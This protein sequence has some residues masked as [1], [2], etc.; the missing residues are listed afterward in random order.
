MPLIGY[1]R[2]STD[3][4]NLGPQL[5][6]LGAAGCTEV[7]EEFAS[8]ANRSRPQLAA[9]IARVRRG[10]TLLVAR[11]DR[12]A[13]SLSHLLDVVETLRA[14]GAYFRSLADP[15]DTSGPSGVLV[16]QMLGAVAEFERSL[17]RERTM[18]GIQ[19]AKA[20]G[21][22]G[23]NPG[24]RARDPDVSRK[25]AA[26]RHA[27]RLAK[28]LPDLE[29]WLPVV[30]RLRPAKPWPDVADA[31]NAAL[32]AGHDRFSTDRLVSSVKLLVSEALAEPELLATAPRRRARKGL[33]S[34][35]RA[36]EVSA[37]LVAG[38]GNITLAQIGTELIRMGHPPPRG[39]NQWAP[40]SV[41]ALLD[42]ARMAG[43]L[44]A[45]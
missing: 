16:L 43:L 19:A 34:R 25:L 38:R 23:G 4:Q 22:V 11:I 29:L 9:A 12:L 26:S 45:P 13:R 3:D 35:Q 27:S 31:V 1:A 40:S 30:R 21:R 15:I 2:V 42:Q 36:Y 17:I 6:A 10:D 18:A 8:G 44:V 39:G 20:R 24:L 7:F 28:L 37:A 5:D 33:I 32:P 14:K 41:K